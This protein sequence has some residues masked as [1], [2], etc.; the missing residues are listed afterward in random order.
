MYDARAAGGNRYKTMGR[1]DSFT[2]FYLIC[3]I[4]PLIMHLFDGWCNISLK[5]VFIPPHTMSNGSM[6]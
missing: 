4:I 5:I 6:R 1:G 3:L 2:G